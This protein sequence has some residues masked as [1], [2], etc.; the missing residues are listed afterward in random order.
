[1]KFTTATFSEFDTPAEIARKL[2]A[3]LVQLQPRLDVGSVRVGDT[4]KLD[5]DGTATVG[6]FTMAEGAGAAKVLTSDA[7]GDGTWETP[8]TQV[9]G[10]DTEVQYNNAGAFGASSN[11]IYIAGGKQLRTRAFQAVDSTGVKLWNAAGQGVSVCNAYGHVGINCDP[12]GGSDLDINGD[13][14]RL[15]SLL[16][17]ATAGATGKTGMITI[18]GDYIYVCVAADTWKRA[19]LSTW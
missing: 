18:D 3:L 1:M 11:L 19:S 15:R 12:G 4:T 7:D 9:A 8:A 5:H 6:A 14:I 13:T 16:T 17:P 2:N 10:S